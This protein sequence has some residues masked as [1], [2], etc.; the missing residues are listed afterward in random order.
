MDKREPDMARLREE[1]DR[2]DQRLLSSLSQRAGLALEIGRHKKS[3][4]LAVHDPGREDRVIGSL[5]RD[6]PG[7]LPDAALKAIMKTI[8][9]SCRSIQEEGRVAYLGPE[10]TYS[11]QAALEFFGPEAEY[12]PLPTIKEVFEWVESGPGRLGLVP[13]ENSTEGGVGQTLDLL[14]ET[15]ARIRGEYFIEVRHALLASTREPDSLTRIYSHPQALGQCRG[16]LAKNVPGAAL[17]ETSSTAEAA[18][19]AAREEGAGA[20]G[21]EI[22]A[23]LKGLNI[24]DRDIQD[25]ETNL[26]RFLILGQEEQA[27]T[28]HDRTSLLIKTRHVPGSLH[29]CLEPLARAGLNLT[30]IES[31]PLKGRPWEYVFFI[32]VQGHQQDPKVESGLAGLAT[33]AESVKV[34]GSYPR[35]DGDPAR[36]PAT[37][38][39]PEA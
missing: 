32:D 11:H 10:G 20:V 6:N 31:R 23:G 28:G 21:S 17:V 2:I 37:K 33:A 18:A 15:E 14:L 26:T 7:P 39:E 4:S 12:R 24:I 38:P 29:R 27:P 3:R 13:A 8:I 1:I 34:L 22:L 36:E 5:C 16:W 19:R 35:T 9:A 30:R 25:Q